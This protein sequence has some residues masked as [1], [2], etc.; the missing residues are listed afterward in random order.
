[1]GWKDWDRTNKVIVSVC[2]VVVVT[3]IAF[4][5][6]ALRPN[7]TTPPTPPPP[8]GSS[9][10]ETPTPSPSPTYECTTATGS[11]CT[12]DLAEK[13]DARDQ[14][15]A[16]AEKTYREFQELLIEA[17]KRGGDDEP[18]EAL[19]ERSSPEMQKLARETFKRLKDQEVTYVGFVDITVRHSKDNPEWPT[20]TIV[21]DAC[22]DGSELFALKGKAK[23]PAGHGSISKAT[24]TMRRTSGEWKLVDNHEK[25]VD[26]C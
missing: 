2:A 15:Y 3:V 19:K 20:D 17:M 5:V 9:Q 21:F 1:M 14:A 10:S 23:E 22:L 26:K 13:E 7:E 18:S 4:A 16:D 6:L 25:K 11:K 8:P 24:A 12:K